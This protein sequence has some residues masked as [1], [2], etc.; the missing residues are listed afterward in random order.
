[1]CIVVFITFN[2]CRCDLFVCGFFFM[3]FCMSI[4]KLSYFYFLDI[5]GIVI[6]IF[7]SCKQCCN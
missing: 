7:F 3:I 6:E 5:C 1:V 2:F 4:L